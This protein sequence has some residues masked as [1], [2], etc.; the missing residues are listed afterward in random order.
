MIT[1]SV[2]F[3]LLMLMYDIMWYIQM[4]YTFFVFLYPQLP[5]LILLGVTLVVSPLVALMIDQLR[6]LPPVIPGALLSS[7]QVTTYLSTYLFSWF[8][9]TH[10]C[11]YLDK[12]PLFSFCF[13]Y[14]ILSFFF[15]Q[16]IEEASETLNRL[17]EGNI[18]ASS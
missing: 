17:R 3:K 16:T 5:A 13:F 8:S 1:F 14:L 15:F 12:M 2:Y 10:T 18:K 7:S 4:N 6:H 11:L 9:C